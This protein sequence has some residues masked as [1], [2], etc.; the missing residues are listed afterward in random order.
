MAGMP[1]LKKILIVYFTDN[2]KRIKF[3]LKV[4]CLL[5]FT[6]EKKVKISINPKNLLIDAIGGMKHSAPGILNVVVERMLL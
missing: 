5:G 6:A 4:Y 2:R 1:K 3:F